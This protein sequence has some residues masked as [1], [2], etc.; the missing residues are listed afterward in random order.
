MH[1]F[2]SRA[3]RTPWTLVEL[4][5]MANLAS[6]AVDVY[7]AHSTN[8]FERWQEWI[9]VGF[10]ATAPL[11]LIIAAALGGVFPNGESSY[12]VRSVNWRDRTA[13]GLGLL[14]DWLSLA[15]G[16]AGM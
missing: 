8:L 12:P 5:A 10:S 2:L 16:I 14:V 3:S 9:P 11:L 13:R 6:L 4:F 7:I 15:V 1:S